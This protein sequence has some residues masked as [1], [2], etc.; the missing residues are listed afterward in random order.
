MSDSKPFY[1]RFNNG[2]YLKITRQG[3]GS[4][5]YITGNAIVGM[6]TANDYIT[7]KSIIKDL[8]RSNGGILN[9][10]K[11][12]AKSSLLLEDPGTLKIPAKTDSFNDGPTHLYYNTKD[13]FVTAFFYIDK[14]TRYRG[15]VGYSKINNKVLVDTGEEQ[16]N[17]YLRK[18]LEPHLVT[19]SGVTSEDKG[20]SD[21]E[22]NMVRYMGSQLYPAPPRFDWNSIDHRIRIFKHEDLYYFTNWNNHWLK[23][24]SKYLDGDLKIIQECGVDTSKLLFEMREFTRE[25][26]G[27]EFIDYHTIIGKSQPKN[28]PAA[29]VAEPVKD[30]SSSEDWNPDFSELPPPE[31]STDHEKKHVADELMDRI[32]AL[33]RKK[34]ELEAEEHV[35]GATMSTQEKNQNKLA[36]K[37]MEIEIAALTAARK[38]GV[39]DIG[40]VVI[41][42]LDKL[43][44]DDVDYV[45]ADVLYAELERKLSKYGTNAVQI[46]QKLRS[47]KVDPKKALREIMSRYG[48]KLKPEEL[49]TRLDEYVNSNKTVL[50]D[51]DI[52]MEEINTLIKSYPD[53]QI[54]ISPYPS[55]DMVKLDHLSAKKSAVPGTGT[56]F[57]KALCEWADR[58]K[59]M[60]VLQTGRFDRTKKN[61]EFK[62]TSSENRLKKFYKR[63]GFISNYGRSYR[64]DLPGNM[65]RPIKEKNM[66]TQIQEN[67]AED[68]YAEYV[69]ERRGEVPFMM[70]DKKYQFVNARYP[71]GKVDIGVYA[72]AGD[73]V[74]TYNAF[75]QMFG[76]SESI[77]NIIQNHIISVLNESLE[78]KVANAKGTV[79]VEGTDY[80]YK[81]KVRV[82]I[83]SGV[84]SHGERYSDVEI[85]E[86]YDINIT[87]EPDNDILYDMVSDAIEDDVYS[88]GDPES[89]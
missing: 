8:A 6:E 62:V 72:F 68:L 43:E 74:Y 65:H 42:T 80:D 70:G 77:N 15:H 11:S 7:V 71:D 73:V 78:S 47:M 20:H 81:C 39:T 37:N 3:Y 67:A 33:D 45:P 1:I 16:L 28:E 29:T 76:I 56:S 12:N 83:R 27:D 82:D 31:K 60:L 79:N 61:S 84:E 48:N 87:P 4:G 13:N 53:L 46:L 22:D 49:I 66:K 54:N 86:V 57:M 63:F 59:I 52:N 14:V 51:S 55:R 2:K 32:R 10:S 25:S 21:L 36:I 64:P 17:D 19:F 35:K 34:S 40:K 89:I 18:K 30:T 26:I 58:N 23:Y 5:Y 38:A 41:N 69:S 75:K 24:K 85:G 9:E 88:K 50:E 44:T